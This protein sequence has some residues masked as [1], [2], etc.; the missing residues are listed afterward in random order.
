MIYIVIKA[1]NKKDKNKSWNVRNE[2]VKGW[3][4]NLKWAIYKY[5]MT[6]I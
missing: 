6:V 3:K 2:T 1:M 4:R 5:K